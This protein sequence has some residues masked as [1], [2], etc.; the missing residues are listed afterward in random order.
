MADIVNLRQARKDK[1][2]AEKEAAAKTNRA[3]HGRT[4]LEKVSTT[5][6]KTKADKDLSAHKRDPK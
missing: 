2:R 1:A 3:A 5:A 4:K 6:Q